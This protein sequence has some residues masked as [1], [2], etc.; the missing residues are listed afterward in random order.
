[1]SD[2]SDWRTDT[3]EK[4]VFASL[5]EA[6]KARRWGIFFKLLTFAYLV[7]LLILLNPDMF[8][9]VPSS[10]GKHTAM[11]DITGI[12]APGA[13]ANADDVIEGLR[14]AFEDKNTK[15]VI[16]RVNSPGGS[17][18]QAGYIN[19]EIARLKEKYPDIPVYAVLS[20]IAASGGYYI[21]VAADEIYA[22]KASIVGSIGVLMNGFGFVD[23][24]DNLG[25]ERRLF[26]AGKYKG[27]LDPFSPLKDGER[28]FLQTLLDQMHSQFIDVVQTGRGDRLAANDELFTGLFWTGEESVSLGLVDGLGSADYV[29]RE[30]I[31]VEDIV[32]FT[33]K[34]DVFS[35]LADR[36]G[37]RAV[38]TFL[39]TNESGIDLR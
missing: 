19:D 7:A 30:K 16:I 36:I 1:M 2:K 35:R 26:T 11:V 17:P 6:R 21:A 39:G 29:A 24:M 14:D 9:E 10:D 33:K 20:D 13:K 5:S 38:Q 22:D 15:G 3:L 34:D 23:I 18:V 37:T 8:G 27:I 4:L 28:E 25:I 32:D 31:G 12:I